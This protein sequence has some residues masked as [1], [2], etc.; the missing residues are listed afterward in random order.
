[1]HEDVYATENVFVK[2][3]IEVIG[4]HSTTCGSIQILAPSASAVAR[5]SL[6]PAA[7]A[8]R[9][10]SRRHAAIHGRTSRAARPPRLAWQ[11]QP[12]LPARHVPKAARCV[13]A[14]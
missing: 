13:S 2:A 8:L 11:A 3:W 1:M 12:R 4:W 5:S 10:G 9:R 6:L 14:R 7:L